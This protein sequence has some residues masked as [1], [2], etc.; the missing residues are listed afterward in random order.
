MHITASVSPNSNSASVELRA[1]LQCLL[2]TSR[3][4][5]T[6]YYGN[7]MISS[8]IWNKYKHE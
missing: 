5:K 3:L 6:V 2:K 7:R 1:M 4:V 8:A